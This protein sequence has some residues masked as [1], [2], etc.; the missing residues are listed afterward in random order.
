MATERDDNGPNG[1]P[2]TPGMPVRVDAYTRVC[3][4]VISVLLAVLI[5][6]LWAR[7]LPPGPQAL[8]VPPVLDP[9]A[10]RA[11]GSEAAQETNRKLDRLLT[12]L[13]SGEVKVQVV[14]EAKGKGAIHDAAPVR[15]RK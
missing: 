7:E 12:L 14:D 15:I 5:V 9:V 10:Q 3:L 2:L 4:T 11:A 8:A 13:T 6:G 1:E